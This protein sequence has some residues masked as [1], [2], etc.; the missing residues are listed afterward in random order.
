MDLKVFETPGEEWDDFASR[1]TDLIFYR[2]VWS[3]VLQKGLGGQPLYFYVKEGSEIVA[4]LPGILLNFKIFK[5][6]YASIPYGNLIGEK[7]YF[8]PFMEL[9]EKEFRTRR[10]DQIRITESPFS[11]S[12]PHET[13]KSIPARCSLLDL[14][15]FRDGRGR[16]NYRGDVRRANLLPLRRQPPSLYLLTAGRS[17]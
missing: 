5:I 17:M 8:H 6:V 3:E 9:I 12:Y 13:F 16:E 4:G 14:H 7:I 11:V 10:I 2:S 15:P 1:Y